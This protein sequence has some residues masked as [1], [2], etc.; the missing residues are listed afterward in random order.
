S[1]AVAREELRAHD[2]SPERLDFRTAP[3]VAS[4]ARNYYSSNASPS[5]TRKFDENQSWASE[6]RRFEVYK[7]RAERDA[8][9]NVHAPNGAPSYRPASYYS[10][11][12]DRPL[13][14]LS[15]APIESK[16]SFKVDAYCTAPSNDPYRTRSR[17]SSSYKKIPYEFR[18]TARRFF[19]SETDRPY[20]RTRS[21]DR[22][23]GFGEDFD[24]AAQLRSRHI[25]PE[26]VADYAYVNYHDTSNGRASAARDEKGQP[27]SI[28]KNKQSVD[29]E[30]RGGGDEAGSRGEG[31]SGVGPVRSVRVLCPYPLVPNLFPPSLCPEGSASAPI[32]GHI[33]VKGNL[34]ETH[35]PLNNYIMNASLDYL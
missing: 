25:T 6:P 35:R 3:Y 28:L 24:Y 7:T 18:P 27:R 21:M 9:R 31:S 12:S 11:A 26:P 23:Q 5:Y 15:L 34:V 10:T 14:H 33:S 1:A 29:V 30:Q 16:H 17:T 19:K 4:D 2:H 32:C 13:T 22:K 20:I 8:E